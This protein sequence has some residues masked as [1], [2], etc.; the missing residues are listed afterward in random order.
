M[1]ITAETFKEINDLMER[2]MGKVRPNHIK[3]LARKLI[4]RFPKRF[5]SDFENNKKIVDVLT[6]VTSTKIRN[7]VAGYITHLVSIGFE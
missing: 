2:A 3:N 4:E 5:N 6:D 1:R 7:R